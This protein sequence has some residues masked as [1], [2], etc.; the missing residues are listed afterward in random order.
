MIDLKAEAEAVPLSPCLNLYVCLTMYSFYFYSAHPFLFFF[1]VAEVDA[2][3][4]YGLLGITNTRVIT[5]AGHA[6]DK[7]STELPKVNKHQLS[8]GV[9]RRQVVCHL[10]SDP[11]DQVAAQRV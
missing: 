3:L 10:K 11:F 8:A 2:G 1:V 4:N 6:V 5:H 7:K 9:L